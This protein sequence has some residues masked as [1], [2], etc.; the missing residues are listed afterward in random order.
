[1]D[2][3]KLSR[4]VTI[5]QQSTTQ[6]AYGQPVQTWTDVATVWA[7]I[8]DLSGREFLAAAAGQSATTSKIRV[9][10]MDGILSSMR[11]VDGADIYNIKV[12]LREG[13]TSLLLMCEKGLNAG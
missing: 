4:R 13:K 8:K 5:Q 11:I 3:G 6:D 10:F 2:I 12:V 1:M 7:E 9:R